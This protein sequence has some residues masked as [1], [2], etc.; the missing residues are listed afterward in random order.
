MLILTISVRFN[1]V[2]QI[3]CSTCPSQP[4]APSSHH[5]TGSERFMK[6]FRFWLRFFI[7]F[8][9]FIFLYFSPLVLEDIHPPWQTKAPLKKNKDDMATMTTATMTTKIMFK[10]WW[11]QWRCLGRWRWR[12]EGKIPGICEPLIFWE[13]SARNETETCWARFHWNAA[14]LASGEFTLSQLVRT[15]TALG[16]AQ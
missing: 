14:G 5:Q 13:S 9:F 6:K 11:W 4:L 7:F 2:C 3:K 15:P 1:E 10:W 16:R 12:V 8:I